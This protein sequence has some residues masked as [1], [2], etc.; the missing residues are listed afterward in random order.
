[1]HVPH[2]TRSRAAWR[3][4]SGAGATTLRVRVYFYTGRKERQ[5]FEKTLLPVAVRPVDSLDLDRSSLDLDREPAR[6]RLSLVP[7]LLVPESLFDNP[8]EES[9]FD[10]PNTLASRRSSS[11]SSCS[12][13]VFPL[14]CARFRAENAVCCASNSSSFREI[15]SCRSCQNSEC[16]LARRIFFPLSLDDDPPGDSFDESNCPLE[17]PFVVVVVC[18]PFVKSISLLG[19]ETGG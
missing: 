8:L 14:P 18:S 6:A 4:D 13:P 16:D 11:M 12:S 3:D 9:L 15:R 10:N 19:L 7:L 5:E 17:T 2:R 1:M